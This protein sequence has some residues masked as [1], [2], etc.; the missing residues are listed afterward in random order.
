MS[1][2]D[3]CFEW[4]LE[5][6]YY[7]AGQIEQNG[8]DAFRDEL[9]HRAKNGIKLLVSRKEYEEHDKAML[10]R[11]KAIVIMYA[12]N[13]LWD[14]F[15]FDDEMIERF[16]KRFDLKAESLNRGDI[17]WEE[18]MSILEQEMNIRLKFKE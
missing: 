7:A 18:Q 17:T 11:L 8:M 1:K 6:M 9:E 15:D 12:I 14:E 16:M 2:R 10:N 4:R 3:K 13:T 5:G